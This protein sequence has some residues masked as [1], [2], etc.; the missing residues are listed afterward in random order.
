MRPSQPLLIMLKFTT[1][2]L[3]KVQQLLEE[4]GYTVRY[5]KGSFQSGYCIVQDRKVVLV[6][7]FYDTE[8][9]I[10]CLLDIIANISIDEEQFSDK[11]AKLYQQLFQAPPAVQASLPL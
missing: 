2:N 10:N 8:G 7:K 5:E 1:N 9:R 4:Q 3:K 11:S 6:N